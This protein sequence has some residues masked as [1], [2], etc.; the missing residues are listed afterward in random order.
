[1]YVC[2][3]RMWLLDREIR[4]MFVRV[5]KQWSSLFLQILITP[6][7]YIVF[8]LEH[9]NGLLAIKQAFPCANRSVMKWILSVMLT[10]W[11]TVCFNLYTYIMHIDKLTVDM[12]NLILLRCRSNIGIACLF[13]LFFDGVLSL[14]AYICLVMQQGDRDLCTKTTKTVNWAQNERVK[15][16]A[17]TC[18]I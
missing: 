10:I 16:G 8:E 5:N 15:W 14:W 3:S 6:T 13:S 11:I 7:H 12:L 18:I 17:Q 9:P 2:L 1:M 4:R